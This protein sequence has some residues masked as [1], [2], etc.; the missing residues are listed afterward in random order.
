MFNPNNVHHFAILVKYV[1][2]LT[3]WKQ[4]LNKADQNVISVAKMFVRSPDIYP[5]S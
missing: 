3:C 1:I 4:K 2:M 5:T